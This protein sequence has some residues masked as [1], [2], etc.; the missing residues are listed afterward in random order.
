MWDS[1]AG[2]R[3]AWESKHGKTLEQCV[4]QIR[5]SG[6]TPRG[7]NVSRAD[8]GDATCAWRKGVGEF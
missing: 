1:N 4:A 5:R 6:P 7:V 2:D 3:Q 8:G